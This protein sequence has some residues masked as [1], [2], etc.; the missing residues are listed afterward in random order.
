V[1][2]A[3]DALKKKSTVLLIMLW[4]FHD[5][6]ENNGSQEEMLRVQL[7]NIHGNNLEK[8]GLILSL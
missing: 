5:K 7:C 8:D 1:A 3:V 4:W 2:N 6:V